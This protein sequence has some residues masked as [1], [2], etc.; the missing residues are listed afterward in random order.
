MTTSRPTSSDW[1]FHSEGGTL[2][3]PTGLIGENCRWLLAAK[4]AEEAEHRARAE[5]KPRYEIEVLAQAADDAKADAH[6]FREIVSAD[7]AFALRCLAEFHPELSVRQLREDLNELAD[8]T[9][10]RKVGAA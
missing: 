2:G 9:L 8:A 3:L 10:G 1:L 4:R 5:G 7:L 6:R